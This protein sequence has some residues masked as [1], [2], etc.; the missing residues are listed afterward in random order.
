M[1]SVGLEPANLVLIGT[2]TT[3]QATGDA[4]VTGE[5]QQLL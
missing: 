3:Y 1:H 2:R 5:K 4:G